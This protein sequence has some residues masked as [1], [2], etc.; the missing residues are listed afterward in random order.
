ML[1]QSKSY[2]RDLRLDSFTLCWERKRTLPPRP[3][4]A[5]TW[6]MPLVPHSAMKCA[7]AHDPWSNH[8]RPIK[9]CSSSKPSSPAYST[10][11]AFSAPSKNI[12]GIT[13]PVS[14][15]YLQMQCCGIGIDRTSFDPGTMRNTTEVPI[16]STNNGQRGSVFR[17]Q[18]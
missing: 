6:K 17:R 7:H 8:A 15:A 5:L 10:M 9:T 14:S 11:A 13:V 1:L 3:D 18:H 4:L 12:P 2:E 16:K